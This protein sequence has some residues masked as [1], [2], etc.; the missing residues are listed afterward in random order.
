MIFCCCAASSRRPRKARPNSI[1]RSFDWIDAH[2]IDQSESAADAYRIAAVR[3]HCA[4]C[5]RRAR[6]PDPPSL[7]TGLAA[8][9]GVRDAGGICALGSGWTLRAILAG[10]AAG[11]SSPFRR[12]ERD[13]LSDRAGV[14]VR[15]PGGLVLSCPDA[16]GIGLSDYGSRPAAAAV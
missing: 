3:F 13:R 8:V 6:G 11:E 14:V 4:G 12:L 16:A 5:L 1:W 9:W 2:G 7:A 15:N 10:G